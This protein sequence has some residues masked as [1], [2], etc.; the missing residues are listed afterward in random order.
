MVVKGRGFKESN[1]SKVNKQA[2]IK[3]GKLVRSQKQIAAF[4]LLKYDLSY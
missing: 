4:E 3:L 1:D 2:K